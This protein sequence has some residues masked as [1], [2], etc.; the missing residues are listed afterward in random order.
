MKMIAAILVSIGVLGGCTQEQI[1]V[2]AEVI[3]I[4]GTLPLLLSSS[5][6]LF[7]NESVRIGDA[8]LVLTV[9]KDDGKIVTLDIYDGRGIS[10]AN[11]LSRVCVGTKISYMATLVK[12][13]TDEELALNPLFHAGT[14]H[15]NEILVPVP[16]VNE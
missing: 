7:G 10:K 3:K 12:N 8:N 15:A 16:C 1:R 5:G 13:K 9:K 4:S 6:A 2:D 14:S 11:I